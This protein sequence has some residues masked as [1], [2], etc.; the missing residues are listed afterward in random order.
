MRRRPVR[1][2]S[3]ATSGSVPTLDF[4]QTER[5]LA[6][7]EIGSSSDVV[8]SHQHEADA[9]K[10]VQNRGGSGNKMMAIYR[11]NQQNSVAQIL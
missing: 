10:A 8:A 11:R 9:G 7:T 6:I 4:V 2:A 3:I 5:R 1:A